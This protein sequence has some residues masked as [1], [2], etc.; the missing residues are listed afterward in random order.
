[1]QREAEYDS[2]L[3]FCKARRTNFEGL[4]DYGQPIIEV[5]K[6]PNML[7]R[8]NPTSRELT[9][10]TKIPAKCMYNDN[11]RLAVINLSRLDTGALRQVYNTCS[12]SII[13]T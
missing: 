1:M 8:L 6:V 2:L 11:V 12:V 5:S 10:S 9:P 4:Y 13:D 7:N 3:G